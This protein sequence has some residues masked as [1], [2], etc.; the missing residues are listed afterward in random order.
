[1]STQEIPEPVEARPWRV[2]D[3]PRPRVW[4]WPHG[5]RPALEV[6]SRGR[7]RYAPVTARQDWADGRRFYQV[8]VDLRG[9]T[10]VCV[11]LYQWPQPGLRTAHRTRSARPTDG[12]EIHRS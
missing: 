4:V 8:E 9:E 6:W 11:R 7:W 12:T 10:S 1:M 2:E 5:D 3:G